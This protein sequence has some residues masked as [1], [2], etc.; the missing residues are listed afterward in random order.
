M[1]LW[2][3]ILL[4]AALDIG[5]HRTRQWVVLVRDGTVIGEGFTQPAGEAHA[6][7]MALTVARE[8]N[9]MNACRAPRPMSP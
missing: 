5:Q 7:V 8:A 9:G 4:A 2:N 3:P 1:R 6:E